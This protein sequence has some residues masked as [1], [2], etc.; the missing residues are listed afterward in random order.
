MNMPNFYLIHCHILRI[1][2]E[3]GTFL[4]DSAAQQLQFEW[5]QTNKLEL[6][7]TDRTVRKHLSI[8]FVSMVAL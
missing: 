6:L 1:S 2:Q 5:S 7:C 8:T 3:I 4:L